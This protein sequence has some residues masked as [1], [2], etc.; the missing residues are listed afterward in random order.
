MLKDL[1]VFDFETCDSTNLR[2]REYVLSGGALPALFIADTQTA[3]RG[4]R[5]KSFYSPKGSGLYMTLA[6]PWDEDL[7]N[8]VAITT[9]VSVAA[10]RVLAKHTEKTLS[11]KWV[12]DIFADSKK[13]AGIL[14]E[15]VALPSTGEIKA[16]I[17]GIGVNLTTKDFPDDIKQDVTCLSDNPLDRKAIT[18]ELTEELLKVVYSD[19][20]TTVMEEYRKK[21][22]VIG[23]E[24]YYI[25]D[26]EIFDARVIGIDDFGGLEII[27]PNSAKA[28]L[29][30]GEI[31][32]RIKPD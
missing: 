8:N 2:A 4:R 19:D 14:S 16:V 5:G 26:G 9:A 13:V 20:K 23:K 27:H 1:N 3:G 30:S 24:I 25:K 32:L 11:I 22:A 29:T 17:I 12:N 28:T 21:S 18:K 7:R 15:M 31:T 10:V 6:L